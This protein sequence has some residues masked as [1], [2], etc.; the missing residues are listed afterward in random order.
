MEGAGHNLWGVSRLLSTELAAPRFKITLF[1]CREQ[2][3]F[4]K[5][6]N[7]VYRLAREPFGHHHQK[8]LSRKSVSYGLIDRF[9]G[10]LLGTAVGFLGINGADLL[11]QTS[12]RQEFFRGVPSQGIAT[13]EQVIN[14]L[15]RQGGPDIQD[16]GSLGGKMAINHNLCG[17]SVP[18]FL[19]I[20]EDPE[21]GWEILPGLANQW[22]LSPTQ[23]IGLWA[24][25]YGIIHALQGSVEPSTLMDATS[26]F[27]EQTAPTAYQAAVVKVIP[28]LSQVQTLVCNQASL[29]EA[30]QH[31]LPRP[32][33]PALARDDSFLVAI[34][35]GLYCS[36]TALDFFQ[37]AVGR[38]AQP[39]SQAPYASLL[40][41][42]LTGSHTGV[43]GI[44]LTWRL[45]LEKQTNLLPRATQLLF[46]W[47]GG[48]LAGMASQGISSLPERRW[49]RV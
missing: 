21:E 28:L 43:R 36:L 48:D 5:V 31:L 32:Q 15:I 25:G 35:L 45:T 2:G 4:I 14:S 41:G 13:M 22:S 40:T 23:L 27:L 34:A 6:H 33:S 1:L 9:Q 17:A 11:W 16:L 49:T 24:W 37:L 38:A 3:S 7:S 30:R 29:A 8:S 42:A 47:A 26:H 18:I 10:A 46:V 20:H 39:D 19:W 12:K 44:P